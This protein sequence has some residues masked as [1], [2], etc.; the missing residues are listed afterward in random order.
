MPRSRNI[1]GRT[2]A[3]EILPDKAQAL[4][5]VVGGALRFARR[6]EHPGST[7]PARAYLALEP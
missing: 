7:I 3:H 6:V 1:G 5:F 2:A 4:A